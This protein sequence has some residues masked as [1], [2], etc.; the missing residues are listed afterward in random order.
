MGLNRRLYRRDTLEDVTDKYTVNGLYFYLIPDREYN[1]Y[2]SSKDGGRSGKGA[3]ATGQEI[4]KMF[5]EEKEKRLE[6]EKSSK[7]KTKKPKAKKQEVDR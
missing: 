7:N 1:I 3:K 5:Q 4:H 6:K 2:F